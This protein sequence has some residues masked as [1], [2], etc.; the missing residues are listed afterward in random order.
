MVI[1]LTG[2]MVQLFGPDVMWIAQRRGQNW[3]DDAVLASADWLESQVPSTQWRKRS[4][5]VDRKFQS[6]K[7]EWAQGRRVALHDSADTIAWY[8]HQA[9]CYA[10]PKLRPDYFLPEGY[11]I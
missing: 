9:R 1:R 7:I 5:A 4:A 8:L 10:D 11:R 2:P 6:A 3:R